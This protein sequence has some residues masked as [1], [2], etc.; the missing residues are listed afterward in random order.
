VKCRG[1]I[2]GRQNISPSNGKRLHFTGVVSLWIKREKTRAAIE[3]FVSLSRCFTCRQTRQLLCGGLSRSGTAEGAL[4]DQGRMPCRGAG[5][6]P[7][8]GQEGRDRPLS[9]AGG[10]APYPSV[11]ERVLQW[12]F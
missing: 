1:N 6:V 8:A 7:S 4:S 2:A 3:N 9:G 5:T 11:S 12:C 10:P